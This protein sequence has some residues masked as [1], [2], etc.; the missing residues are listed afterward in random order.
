MRLLLQW[1]E[2]FSIQIFY[3]LRL[4]EHIVKTAPTDL[5]F[6]RKQLLASF[7]SQ[8][9]PIFELEPHSSNQFA[10]SSASD[11]NNF[12]EQF[13][14][15]RTKFSSEIIFT[16]NWFSRISQTP[17]RSRSPS[18]KVPVWYQYQPSLTA[19]DI[20]ISNTLW[21]TYYA[22]TNGEG[23]WILEP[24]NVADQMCHPLM[25]VFL[26]KFVFKVHSLWIKFNLWE[27]NLV[28]PFQDIH[29]TF[30]RSPSCRWD[31]SWS[32]TQGGCEIHLSDHPKLVERV[33]KTIIPNLSAKTSQK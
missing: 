12:A 10:L 23:V 7:K 21:F 25:E 15:S 13:H 29:Q 17:A 4:L 8:P 16:W 27:S 6:I 26:L 33:T 9:W 2:T 30:R 22:I 14:G 18:V 11:Q 3:L 19:V 20:N 31:Q 24:F 32:L 5:C 1:A 28:F